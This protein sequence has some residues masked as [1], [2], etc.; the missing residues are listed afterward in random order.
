MTVFCKT[1]DSL[2]EA[3]DDITEKKIGQAI[4]ETQKSV[5]LFCYSVWAG[6]KATWS[7]KQPN[8]YWSGQ[9]RASV[10]VDVGSADPSFAPDNPGPWPIHPHPYP[11]KAVTT[12]EGTLSA[13]LDF[14]NPYRVV[15]LSDNA[16][17]AAKVE[18]HTGIAAKA[19]ENTR[20]MAAEFTKSHFSSGDGVI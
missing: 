3:L 14:S 16:P 18:S 9:Y 5:A 7:P 17:H 8:D 1:L 4:V 15:Y 11:A 2:Q 10:T 20:A 13:E 12:I 19:A 6:G